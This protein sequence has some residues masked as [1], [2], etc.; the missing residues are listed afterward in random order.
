MKTRTAPID[1]GE[2]HDEIIGWYEEQLAAPAATPWPKSSPPVLIGPTWKTSRGRW[3]LPELTLGWDVLA[4][5]GTWLQ[6][7]LGEPWRFTLEQ[8]RWILWWYALEEDGTFVYHDG[9]LQRLKGWGKDPVAACL[10]AVE[11]FGPCRFA[12]WEDDLPVATDVEDAWIQVAAV[13]LEQTKNTMRLFPGLFTA[14]AKRRF[15]MQVGKEKIHGLGDRRLIEAVT[16][17]PATL[18]GARSTFVEKN[19]T[20]HWTA[21]NDGHDMADVIERNAAKSEDGGART[22]AITNAYEPGEDSSAQRDREAWEKIEAGT[23]RATGLL[24]DS[25][26]APPT[27]KLTAR[28]APKVVVAIRGDSVWLSPNRIVKSILDPRNPPSRSRRWWYNQITATEDAWV[29]PREWDADADPTFTVATGA[30]ITLGFDG[31]VTDD[32]TALIGCDVAHDHLFEI[33]IWAPSEAT[34]EID[35][36]AVDRKVRETVELY[37]VVGFYAD[38]HPWESYVDRWAQDFGADLVVKS[39]L[40]QPVAFDIR[41]RTKEFTIAIERLHAAI[42]ESAKAAGTVSAKDGTRLTHDGA[43]WFRQ[44]VHNARRAPNAWGISVRKEHRESARK[45]DAVP[46]AALAR[47]ARQDYLALPPAKRRRKKRSGRVW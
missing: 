7:R 44:H 3:V 13:S 9:V 39:T 18:E 32:H 6:H 42:V 12:E 46:A 20:Q 16:S 30:T 21:S 40:R 1:V 11:A 8:A 29:E 33:E 17:S 38:L 31:S 2:T 22:L 37:D 28:A 23:S 10:C 15:R 5:C 47:Q 34:G 27:A 36:A 45:I 4:W 26:E 43:A 41:A 25:V 35:R 14:E 19:E 24:Y